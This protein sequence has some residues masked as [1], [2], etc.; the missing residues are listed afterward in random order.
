[1]A[2]YAAWQKWRWHVERVIIDSTLCDGCM[3]CMAVCG[4]HFP[5]GQS[6]LKVRTDA[7]GRYVPLICRQCPRPACMQGCMSGA[8]SR[9]PD[10]GHLQY[11]SGRCGSC[12]MCVMNCPY[13][14]PFPTEDGHV[15]RCDHCTDKETPRCVEVCQR[16]A[17][18]LEEG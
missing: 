6:R 1:M 11:D 15:A 18:Y 16:H 17:I 12:Y 9:C 2:G 5:D 8:I 10:T 13:G 3:K 7:K 4:G 14:I